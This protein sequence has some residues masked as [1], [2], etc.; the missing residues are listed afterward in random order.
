MDNFPDTSESFLKPE[1]S[2][3]HVENEDHLHKTDKKTDMRMS[4]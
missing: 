3:V 1:T 2:L 4:K